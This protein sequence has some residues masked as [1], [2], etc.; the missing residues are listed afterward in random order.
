[1][2]FL[3]SENKII[4]EVLEG[5]LGEKAP[6]PVEPLEIRLCDF[7][8]W[9]DYDP[10]LPLTVRLVA[11]QMFAVTYPEFQFVTPKAGFDFSLQV[12]VDTI[13]LDNAASII[14]RIS[15]LKRNILGAP[16]EQC[17]EALQNGNASTLGPVQIPYR[18]DEAIYVLPQADRIVIVY[19]VCFDDKTDQAIARVFLQV[20]L[21]S[22]LLHCKPFTSN[23]PAGICGHATHSEQRASCCIWQGPTT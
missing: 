4:K 19:S 1:M 7:D 5:R 16:F 11:K 18:R 22:V 10:H 14:K 3:E 13:T 17:F 15:I 21:L 2:L 8:G 9:A 20:R 23:D 12:N 6:R